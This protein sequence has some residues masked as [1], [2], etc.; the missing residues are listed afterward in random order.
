MLGMIALRQKHPKV[1]V[2]SARPVAISAAIWL[3][4]ETYSEVCS[5]SLGQAM[6]LCQAVS[7]AP[8][9]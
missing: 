3:V 2:G 7:L 6:S 8:H 1:R 5:C 9:L 4:S